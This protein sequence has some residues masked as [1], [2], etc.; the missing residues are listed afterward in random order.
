MAHV[1][2]LGA[3]VC[4]YET[5]EH[6]HL[7]IDVA[8]ID[9]PGERW[10]VVGEGIPIGIEIKYDRIAAVEAQ[11]IDQESRQKGLSHP[12]PGRRHDEY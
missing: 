7:A 8:E 10:E 1:H 3:P 6:C 11:E 4:L 5:I 2:Y 12:C 9:R